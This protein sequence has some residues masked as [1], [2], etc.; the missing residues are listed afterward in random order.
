MN[1]WISIDEFSNLFRLTTFFPQK[2]YDVFLHL[3][4]IAAFTQ[5]L[6]KF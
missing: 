1:E 4:E 6:L 2:N 5:S 3:Y